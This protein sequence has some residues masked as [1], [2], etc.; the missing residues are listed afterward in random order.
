MSTK[1]TSAARLH[2][3]VHHYWSF[4]V[5]GLHAQTTARRRASRPSHNELTP[6]GCKSACETREAVRA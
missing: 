5:R 4:R 6:Q 3:G 1:P 2:Y